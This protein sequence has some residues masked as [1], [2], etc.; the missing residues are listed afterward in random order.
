M[1]VQV[2]RPRFYSGIQEV[3]YASSSPEC[4]ECLHLV[5]TVNVPSVS[6]PMERRLMIVP[7][8]GKR[9]QYNST[10]LI[11]INGVASKEETEFYLGKRLA[12]VYK[13]KTLKKGTKYRVMWG[14][15]SL[16][17]SAITVRISQ[18]S[19]KSFQQSQAP[20]SRL[21]RPCGF[22]GTYW[23]QVT[24]A[25]GSA[26]VIRAKFRKNL[27]P[28]SLVRPWHHALSGL[29]LWQALAVCESLCQKM[30]QW[31]WLNTTC[32]LDIP[33]CEDEGDIGLQRSTAQKP[34]SAMLV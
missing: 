34:D 7:R 13:A 19:Q 10:S 12:Y 4:A 3:S 23:V 27:P 30:L 29:N 16:R 33:V 21:L 17:P 14:K 25:H 5:D 1:L 32:V 9:T 26:G 8:R 2:I 20:P 15:V 22:E 6:K 24:R 31:Q 18:G 28:S 11:Q